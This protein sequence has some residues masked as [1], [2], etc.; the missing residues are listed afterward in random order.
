MEHKFVYAHES[1]V[2]AR[3]SGG[4]NIRLGTVDPKSGDFYAHDCIN[5]WDYRRDTASIP[6]TD[7]AFKAKVDRYLRSAFVGDCLIKHHPTDA[8]TTCMISALLLLV[9]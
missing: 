1:G 6:L 2:E 8:A 9:V 3:W 5:V 7:E 4:A